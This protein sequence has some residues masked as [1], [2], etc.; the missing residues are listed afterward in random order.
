VYGNYLK[1]PG[2]VNLVAGRRDETAVCSAHL[3]A[4]EISPSNH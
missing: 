1:P 3:T 4:R 2:I